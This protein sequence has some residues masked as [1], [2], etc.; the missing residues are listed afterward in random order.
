MLIMIKKVAVLS[1]AIGVA[2]T[3]A[4]AF[5]STSQVLTSRRC[6][7]RVIVPPGSVSSSTA[8]QLTQ[9]YATGSDP[10]E[11]IATIHR[12]ADATFAVIDVDGGGT[13][14]KAGKSALV[15]FY[16]RILVFNVKVSA[17]LD[18]SFE[19]NLPLV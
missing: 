4:F 15:L 16:L 3:G 13:L 2:S 14:S 17:I 5:S 8:T 1:L 9:L 18:T 7:S 11:E 6:T 12:N 10:D 19:L